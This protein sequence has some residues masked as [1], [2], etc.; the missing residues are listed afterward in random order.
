EHGDSSFPALHSASVGGQRLLEL[1]DMNEAKA[2]QAFELARTA[3]Y[4]IIEGKGATYYAIGA[5]IASILKSIARD[6]RSVLPVTSPL[7]NYYGLNDVALSVPCIVGYRGIERTMM[8]ELSEGEQ[9]SLH[10]SAEVV[11]AAQK[12]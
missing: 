11:R 3:A 1:P 5:V 4:K 2:R 8:I 6:A 10:T 9:Q 7:N 12:A